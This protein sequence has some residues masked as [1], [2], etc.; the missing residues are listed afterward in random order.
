MSEELDGVVIHRQFHADLTPSGDGRTLDVRVI[1]YGEVA[2]VADS[3][4]QKPYDEVWEKGAFDDQ[5]SA[6]N[7]VDVLVNYEH[8]QGIGGVLGRGVALRSTDTGLEGTFRML[9]G[10]DADKALE[11]V[12]EGILTGISAEAKTK[13]SII[14]PSGLVR[15]VKAQLVN[16]A[17]TRIPAFQSAEIL[18]VREAPDPEPEPAPEPPPEDA[19]RTSE[20]DEMLHRVG[21]EPMTAVVVSRKPWNPSP[22]NYEDASAYARACLIDLGGEEKDVARCWLPVYEPS[23]DLN[24]N[25]LEAAAKRISHAPM[26]ERPAAARKLLRL[27]RTASMD[28]PLALRQLASR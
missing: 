21:F 16:I 27:Y 14:E 11:L 19:A 2:R 18:A 24:V 23:G 15:R 13:K 22:E 3:P 4:Y 1:P 7:R 26:S 12:N 8:E 17:L 10:G 20:I 9:S 6:A 5:L 25:A 28:A